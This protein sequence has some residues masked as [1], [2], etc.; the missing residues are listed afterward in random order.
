[1]FVLSQSVCP[2]QAFPGQS[3]VFGKGLE[4]TLEWSTVNGALALLVK[5]V[6]DRKGLTGTNTKAYCEQS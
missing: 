2:R 6:V 5:I 3:N 4:P 1:M